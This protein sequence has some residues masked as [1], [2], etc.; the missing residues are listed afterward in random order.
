MR[1]IQIQGIGSIELSVLVITIW[2]L[3]GCVLHKESVAQRTVN[4][5]TEADV[6]SVP[7]INPTAPADPEFLVHTVR[8]Q[9]ECLSIIAKWY[10]GNSQTW[11]I[12][13]KANPGLNP[14]VIN[15]GDT[16]LIPDQLLTTRDLLPQS[17]IASP[18]ERTSSD[19]PPSNQPQENSEDLELFGPK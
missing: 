5:S 4:P 10:T 12:I 18:S 1:I 16:I 9:G 14:N 11:K 19:S 6:P 7:A 13:A 8:W 3:T 2:I 17:Y 15:I